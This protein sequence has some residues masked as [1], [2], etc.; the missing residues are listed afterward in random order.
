MIMRTSL[1]F[2]I[3]AAATLAAAGTA[4]AQAPTT[5]A[6]ATTAATP[7]T[8]W[9]AKSV[10]TYDLVVQADGRSEPATLIIATDSA[11]ALTAKVVEGPQNDEHPLKVQVKGVDLVCESPTN[12]GVMVITFQRHGDELVGHWQAGAGQGAITGKLRS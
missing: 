9:T 7:A 6:P 11:G 10:G 12:N 5:T 8:P 2:T 4:R 3:L 1:A